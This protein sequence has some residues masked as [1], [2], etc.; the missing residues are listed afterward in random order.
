MWCTGV[1]RS[2]GLEGGD[3][4]LDLRLKE[5]E[6]TVVGAEEGAMVKEK[7]GG[8]ACLRKRVESADKDLLCEM[9]KAMVEVLMGAEAD[10]VPVRAVPRTSS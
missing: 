4:R 8:L 10:S 3:H 9:V 2:R 6:P 1:D 7:V 5:R